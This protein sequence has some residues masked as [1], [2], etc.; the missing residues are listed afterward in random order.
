MDFFT[1]SVC[2]VMSPYILKREA[3]IS[4][5]VPVRRP[6]YSSMRSARNLEYTDALIVWMMVHLKSLQRLNWPMFPLSRGTALDI[7]NFM[8]LGT[9]TSGPG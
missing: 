2:A 6:V 4:G 9:C 5:M 8:A 3:S 7:F 1:G